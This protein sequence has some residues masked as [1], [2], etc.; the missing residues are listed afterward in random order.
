MINRVLFPIGFMYVWITSLLYGMDKAQGNQL[1]QILFCAPTSL[2]M[3]YIVL[4]LKFNDR[5]D[6]S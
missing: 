3:V 2:V 6:V 1:F 4:N 5:K